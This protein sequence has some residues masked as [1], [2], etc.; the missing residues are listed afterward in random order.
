MTLIA[1]LLFII[2]GFVR[3]TV[4]VLLGRKRRRYVS[5][6]DIDAPIDVVWRTCAARE[7]VFDGPQPI[8]IKVAPRPGAP[9]IL[10]GTVTIGERSVPMAYREIESRPQQAIVIEILE[11]GSAPNV[12]LGRDYYVAVTL[13]ERE[14]GTRLATIHELTHRTFGGRLLVPLGARLNARRLKRHCETEVGTG[15]SPGSRLGAALMTGA[16]TYASFGYMFDWGFA[17]VLFALLVIHEAGHALAMRWVGLPVQ[18]IYFLPF[19]GGVAVAA[20]PHRTETERGFVA[21]MGPG[22]SLVTTAG[23]MWA[24]MVTGEPLFEQ[25][26]LASALLNGINLAPVLPLDGGQIVD[27]ALSR[28]DPE[29]ASIVN[30]LALIAGAGVSVYL[31]WYVLTAIL[32]LAAPAVMRSAV[33]KRHAEPICEPGRAWLV[34]AYLATLAFYVAV[35]TRYFV[36]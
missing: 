20:A 35:T 13:E 24:G 25:L 16:L 22:L 10:E 9:D 2:S 23:F 8:A 32:L 7:I 27:A 3:A 12:A 14:R 29:F 11:D 30:M 36:L 33:R 15:P 17:A 26:A 18:G 31:E 19:I 1:D 5:R 6:I 34:A 4:D 21:L 28:S